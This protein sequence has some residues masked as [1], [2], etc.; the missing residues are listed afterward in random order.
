[1]P[2]VILSTLQALITCCNE[3]GL[4]L[5][6]DLPAECDDFDWHSSK[7]E[8]VSPVLFRPDQPESP[9]GVDFDCARASLGIRF[10]L[11]YALR[12]TIFTTT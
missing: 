2:S 5:Y 12:Y 1:V 4:Q 9:V 10:T 8:S 6:L 11:H 3:D 7:R